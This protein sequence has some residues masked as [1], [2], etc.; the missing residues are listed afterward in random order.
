MPPRTGGDVVDRG[1][2][3]GR[4]GHAGSPGRGRRC[5]GRGLGSAAPGGVR[6]ASA[7]R[8]LSRRTA[9]AGRR[10]ARRPGRGRGAARGPRAP[11]SSRARPVAEVVRLDEVPA[12]ASSAVAQ[13]R[14]AVEL[15]P[16][17][18]RSARG[19][20]RGTARARSSCGHPGVAAE[21][22]LGQHRGPLDLPQPGRHRPRTY[23]SDVDVLEV[24]R[25]DPPEADGGPACSRS[26]SRSA[27]GTP[28]TRRG[29]WRAGRSSTRTRAGA[30][31]PRGPRSARR[32]PGCA[33]RGHRR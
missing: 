23:H 25:R 32:A 8:P 17:E 20:R 11:T 2:L 19:A 27:S 18:L 7:R 5:G 12:A 4:L 28:A 24:A 9:P 21:D 13:Q 22:G 1:R 30:R 29:C 31:G 15:V 6:A 16:D 33:A 3:G 26:S 10:S 14:R